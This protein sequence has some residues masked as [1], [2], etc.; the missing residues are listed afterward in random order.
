[1][2]TYDA[3]LEDSLGNELIQLT[4]LSAD[5]M[6]EKG[7]SIS[8]EQ[9]LY[10]IITEKHLTDTFPNAEIALRMYLVVMVANS[11]S[12]RSFSK[13]K[14]IKNRLRTTMTQERLSGL[15]LLSIEHDI[16]CELDFTDIIEEF[17]TSKARRVN[18]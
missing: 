6:E 18:L 7:D 12:E 13:L 15:S 9:F 8:H 16:L 4:L 14:L 3:D 11:S 2:K 17:A 1:M 10:N 5:F